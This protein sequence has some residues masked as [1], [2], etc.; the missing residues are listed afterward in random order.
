MSSA[1]EVVLSVLL[2]VVLVSVTA[3]D[4]PRIANY[5]GVLEDVG[6]NPIR[7]DT[8][9]V[10][11]QVYD[12]SIGGS[13][14]WSESNLIETDKAGVFAVL[15][16][17]I[18][19]LPD[20][21]FI[22][23]NR[24]LGVA[25]RADPEMTPRIRLASVPYAYYALHADSATISDTAMYAMSGAN[26]GWVD[27]G[28]IVRLETTGD[29]VGIG[30]VTPSA[31]L[32]VAGDLVVAGKATIGPGHTNSGTY[33]F[34]AGKENTAIGDGATVAGGLEN[35]AT[36]LYHPTVGGG[37]LNIAGHNSSTVAGGN[38]NSA[39]GSASTVSGGEGNFALGHHSIIP[40]GYCDTAAGGHSFVAGRSV[41]ASADAEY[42]FAFGKEFTTSTPNAA[43]FVVDNAEFHVGIGVANPIHYIDVY[44]GAYCDGSQWVNAS[45][46]EY[47]EHIHRLTPD[48]YQ[49]ILEKLV[50]GE[51]VRYRTKVQ[52]DTK[53][54][55]GLIAEE[56]PDEVTDA[57]KKGILTGDAIGFLIAAIKAQ[58]LEIDSLRAKVEAMESRR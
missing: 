34:V 41:R 31:M 37:R 12:D 1:R 58:Q 57:Q 35:A 20:S 3:A 52:S 22:N 56:A 27:D 19:P 13:T 18:V 47:R 4:V 29:L 50:A 53:T 10:L 25:V 9:T 21:A 46:I 23:S 49:D 33:S 38:S 15:L 17:L 11:F 36:A 40:G 54:H 48:E 28:S 45:S 8:A 5:Q 30:T 55:L 16:G 24:W 7:N 6:G 2:I 32:D 14:L 39:G 44:P 42:T 26:S 51:V 43:V